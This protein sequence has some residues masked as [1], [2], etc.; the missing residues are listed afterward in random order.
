MI[1]ARLGQAD[2]FGD[3]VHGGRLIAF[4]AHHLGGDPIDVIGAF[5]FWPDRGWL[6]VFQAG[7]HRGT[8]R[9]VTLNR[10]L[11]SIVFAPQDGGRINLR[12]SVRSIYRT[13]GWFFRADSTRGVKDD[14]ATV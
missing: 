14:R 12:P 8:M 2:R 3:I 13:G 7:V 4:L 9:Q 5:F 6:F 10:T 1:N 11:K